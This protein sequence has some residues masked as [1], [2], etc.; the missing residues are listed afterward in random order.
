MKIPFSW[1]SEFVD[2][3]GLDPYEV[4]N[5]LAMIGTEIESVDRIEPAF[6][7]VIT[8]RVENISK[9]PN[10]DQLSI[11]DVN[12]GDEQLKIICGAKNI[13]P[14]NMVPLALVGARLSGDIRVEKRKIR[15]IESVG[16]ICSEVELG[17]GDD[18]SGILILED[19]IPLGEDFS[20][21]T[22]QEDW[23]LNLEITPNRVD[24]MSIV[25]V[26]REVAAA[27]ERRII[28]PKDFKA[29]IEIMQESHLSI[30]VDDAT[31]CPRYTACCLEGISIGPSPFW[32]RQRLRKVGV[33][34]INNVVD[35]TNYVL[36][37]MG[38]PMHAFDMD[39]IEQHKIVVRRAKKGEIIKTLDGTVRD[40]TADMIL[41]TDPSGPIALAGIMGGENTEVSDKTRRVIIESANFNPAMIMRASKQTGLRTEASTRFEKGLDPNMTLPAA[42]RCTRMIA[43][44][45][46][47]RMFTMSL[48]VYPD[49]VVPWKVGVRK[50]KIN[51]F[52]GVEVNN[53][54][55]RK[56]F[57][58]LQIDCRDDGDKYELTVPTFRRDLQMEVDILEEISRLFGYDRFPSTLPFN[59][60]HVGYRTFEQK[61]IEVIRNCIAQTGLD[62]VISY[63]FSNES[64]ISRMGIVLEDWKLIKLRNPIVDSHSIMRPML[65][66]GLLEIAAKNFEIGCPS[67][68][69]FELS[70][71]YVYDS[72]GDE[73]PAEKPFLCLVVCGKAQV[74]DLYY[75]ERDFDFFDLKGVLEFLS[76]RLN[77]RTFGL[78]P[79]HV[80]YLHPAAS[81]MV[82]LDGE[83]VGTM[84]RLNPAVAERFDLPEACYVA[85]ISVNGLISHSCK[86]VSS[87][88]P[89]KFPP[90]KLD[91]AMV[92]DENISNEDIL[93]VLRSSAGDLLDE[94][95]LFDVFRGGQI[96]E[97]KKS[98]A[99]SLSFR[100]DDRTLREQEAIEVFTR[101]CEV[102]KDKMNVRIREKL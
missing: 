68:G 92:V 81:Y 38:Q 83:N 102:L 89:G 40:T 41:I 77:V 66:P 28:S 74:K 82:A 35:A 26:A 47:A 100:R 64:A 86:K 6:E 1:L 21:V 4:A 72:D 58:S 42:V 39:R 101:I 99:Y 59:R 3:E 22:G 75:G 44:L 17:V 5:K 23:I 90:V 14:G 48:D 91:I 24:C 20:R 8:A 98:M 61:Q 13:K 57:R 53:A 34:P 78:Q 2:L 37:E 76:Q 87:Y 71:T 67:I 88:Q 16:M 33:R 32:V 45:S 85:E 60:G 55:S 56:I 93:S 25:G 11:C 51:S 94:V 52:L 95:V 27:F 43:K 12:T 49:P 70:K 7:N 46:G 10:A 63:S 69:V 19:D 80:G 30:E 9:H 84:G 97:G 18:H 54:D 79:T 65:L 62:E 73:L 31:I 36:F 50:K 29:D 96:G 15:G